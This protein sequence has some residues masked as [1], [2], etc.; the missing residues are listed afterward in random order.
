MKEEHRQTVFENGVLGKTVWPERDVVTRE[1]R[2]LHN[3]QLYD[4]YSAP[5]IIHVMKSRR[6]RQERHVARIG[7]RR[8]A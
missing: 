3:E 5:N 8:G 7:D 4:L 6:K 2:W 1:C